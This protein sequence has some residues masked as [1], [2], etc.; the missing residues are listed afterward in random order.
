MFFRVSSLSDDGFSVISSGL[1][2][3]VFLNDL[4]SK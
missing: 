3:F 4:V 2:M 1:T